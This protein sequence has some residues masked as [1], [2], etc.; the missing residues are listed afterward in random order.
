MANELTTIPEAAVVAPLPANYQLT[1]DGS[2]SLSICY[3]WSCAK[4]ERLQFTASELAEVATQMRACPGDG[5][6]ERL[7]RLRIGIWR[8]ELLAKHYV[9]VLGNDLAVNDQDSEL[10]GR[11]DCV[12]NAT[13]TSTYLAILRDLGAMPGWKVGKPRVRDGLTIDVHWTATVIDEASGDQWAVDSWFRPQGHLPFVSPVSDWARG[14]KPWESP[15]GSLQSLSPVNP[16]IVS[17]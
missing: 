12:D 3:N 15:P 2:A 4:V 7:Q 13:N 14:H 5:L 8:M 11:T 1:A 16:L 10:E 17:R 9:P 6:Y